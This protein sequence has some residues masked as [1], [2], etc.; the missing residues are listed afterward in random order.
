MH[1]VRPSNMRSDG[2]YTSG[3]FRRRK[4][5][6]DEKE[7]SVNWIQYWS[8]CGFKDPMNQI[9]NHFGLTTARSGKFAEFNVGEVKNS[10]GQ[11]W[12]PIWIVH[13]PRDYDPSHSQIEPFPH[14]ESSDAEV[15]ANLIARKVTNL[16]PAR[17][18]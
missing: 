17:D 18:D 14:P 5:R 8:N 4:D 15:V 9:R 1:Y 3:S 10:I 16:H 12:Q 6:P 11:N 13:S 7:L 2:T